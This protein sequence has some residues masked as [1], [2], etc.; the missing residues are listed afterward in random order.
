ML[1]ET[2]ELNSIA[3]PWLIAFLASI[4]R[5]GSGT[6]DP[7]KSRF[8]NKL[9]S[10]DFRIELKLNISTAVFAFL[11][12]WIHHWIVGYSNWIFRLSTETSRK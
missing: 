9:K 2:V 8:V 3:N 1:I 6:N 10:F 12:P 7:S 5:T 11:D 4:G